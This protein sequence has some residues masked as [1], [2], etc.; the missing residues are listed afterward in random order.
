MTYKELAEY[1]LSLPAEI[2]KEK[3]FI[4]FPKYI[5]AKDKEGMERIFALDSIKPCTPL[6]KGNIKVVKRD[7]KGKVILDKKGDYKF[8][9]FIMHCLTTVTARSFERTLYLSPL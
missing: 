9:E 8:D 4:A 2:Q 7:K 5:P 6:I 3:A 1:L